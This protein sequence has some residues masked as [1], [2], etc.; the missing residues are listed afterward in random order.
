[1]STQVRA[2][3]VISSQL[4]DQTTLQRIFAISHSRELRYH[5]VAAAN[6]TV[7]DILII[8]SEL[9]QTFYPLRNALLESNP[10]AMVVVLHKSRG[11]PQAETSLTRPL[12]ATRVLSTLD[13]VAKNAM[14]SN[15]PSNTPQATSQATSQASTGVPVQARARALVVDDSQ[16]VRLQVGKALQR[17]GIAAQFADSGDMALELVEQFRFDIIFLDVVMPGTDGYDVCRMIKHDKARRNTPIVMLTSKS[18]TVNKIKAKFCGCDSYLTKPVK[19][20]EFHKTVAK[21]LGK[22][23]SVVPVSS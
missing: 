1:M 14:S 22:V 7:C 4:S 9:P 2:V 21:L 20:S 3:A 5:L 16:T 23:G 19:V 8:E 18:S 6:D 17:Y 13:H 15:P 10:R 11:E 12:T